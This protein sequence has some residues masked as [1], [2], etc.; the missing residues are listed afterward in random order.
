MVT[1]GQGG[2]GAAGAG[3]SGGTAVCEAP[4]PSAPLALLT[5]AQYDNTVFDL[6]GDATHPSG[7]FPPENQV[8]GFKNNTSA[9]QASPLLVETLLDAAEGIASRAVA[10]RLESLAPCATGSTPESCGK[11]FVRE[12]G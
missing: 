1:P 4:P 7:P 3:G 9:H 12:F 2:S 11:N 5:R 6:L 10:A 8:Q